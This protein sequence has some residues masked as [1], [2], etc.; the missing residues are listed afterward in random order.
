[1]PFTTLH[2]ISTAVSLSDAV[3]I[4]LCCHVMSRTM[5]KLSKVSINNISK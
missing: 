4:I 5:C 3:E 1:M 2:L